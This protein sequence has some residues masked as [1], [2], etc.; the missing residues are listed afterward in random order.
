MKSAGSYE[1]ASVDC[2]DIITSDSD[3]KA[4]T[5]ALPHGTYTVHQTKGAE[6]H[7]LAK[8][9]DV[10]ITADTHNKT[11]TYKLT[12]DLVRGKV[13]GYKTG[14]KNE[15]LQGALFGLFKNDEEE[16]TKDTALMTAESNEEGTFA[17]SDVPYGEYIVREIAAPL[18]YL[19]SDEKHVVA[20][21]EEGEVI[22]LF[23]VNGAKVGYMRF[24]YRGAFEEEIVLAPE[25]VFT[26]VKTGD[27]F[28]IDLWIGL[29]AMSV[30]ILLMLKRTRTTKGDIENE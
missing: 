26:Q 14:D 24:L 3:G 28:D 18:G 17:F 10:V 13:I 29:T 25:P 19:L 2:R 12:N 30:T 21:S 5:K 11:Y 27:D 22:E 8:D 1:N 9:F 20:I 4:A 16:F 15:F 23:A 7:L 6:G